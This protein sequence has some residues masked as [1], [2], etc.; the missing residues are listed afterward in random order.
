MGQRPN[1]QQLWNTFFVAWFVAMY[2]SWNMSDSVFR[3]WL[4]KGLSL[5]TALL[6]VF[7]GIMLFMETRSKRDQ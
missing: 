3:T 7:L 1:Y 6:S 4:P 5:T 2:T